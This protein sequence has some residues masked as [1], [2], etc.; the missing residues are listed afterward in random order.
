MLAAGVPSSARAQEGAATQA[1][2]AGPDLAQRALGILEAHCAECVDA[3]LGSTLSLDDMAR[4]PSLVIPK[5]PDASRAYHVLLDIDVPAPGP[6]ADAGAVTAEKKPLSPQ[7]VET[8]RDWIESLPTVDEV[9]ADRLSVTALETE[10]QAARWLRSL[11]EAEAADTRFISLAHLYSACLSEKRIQELRE[12]MRVLLAALGQR[13]EL[14]KVETLGDASTLLAIRLSDVGITA[15]RWANLIDGAPPFVATAVP[16]DWLAA[17]VLSRPRGKGGAIDSTFDAPMF[18]KDEARVE[19]LARA[20][21]G[22]VDLRRAAAELG[23][24]GPEM[25]RKP[26][27]FTADINDLGQR[28]AQGIVTRAEWDAVKFALEGGTGAL[29]KPA[30]NAGG[31]RIN[32]GLWTDK[33]GYRA[34]DL[35]Q[36]NVTV[37]RACY[38]T[39]IDVDKDGKAIVLFPNDSET[40]NLVQPGATV[41]VPNAIAGYQLRFDRAGRETL[42]A[43]CQRAGPRMAGLTL[44]YEKQRFTILGDW[45]TFLRTAPAREEAFQRTQQS[46]SRRGRKGRG[47]EDPPPARPSSALDGPPAVGRAAIQVT[48]D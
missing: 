10:A 18:A 47:Q 28:L 42:V 41:K 44:D 31:S 7:D 39:L 25:V 35:V 34:G 23:V 33:L 12:S 45:R 5:Q 11:S 38:L 29:P 46:R 16:G 27:T 37:D 30:S 20:W 8:V 22:D 9:C 19:A 40:E 4:D 3:G 43:Q 17:R 32:V 24:D 2:S 14:P 6:V 36:V 48:I 21:S 26:V 13:S 15:A 1:A